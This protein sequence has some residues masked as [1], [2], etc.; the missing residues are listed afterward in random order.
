MGFG[1]KARQLLIVLLLLPS[2]A[3]GALTVTDRGTGG[4]GSVQAS[5]TV[6]PASN[7]AAG[8]MGVLCYSGDNANGGSGANVP[9]TIVDSVGNTWVRRQSGS[10]GT[11]N[12]LADSA[13]YT[14]Q[15][16]TAFTT[17]DNLVITFVS[18]VTAKNWTLSEIAPA[19]GKIALYSRGAA[20]SSS[21]TGTPTINAGVCINQAIIGMAAA[22]SA[23]TFTGDADTT[24]G[25]WSTKQSTGV[26]SGASGNSILSQ[27][28]VVT[29][30]ADQTFN[31]TLTS[32]DVRLAWIGVEE[33]DSR[34]RAANQDATAGA[35]VTITF[36]EPIAAGSTAVLCL[37]ADNAGSNGSAANIPTSLT[38]SKSN[39][40][41]LRSTVI[42]DPGAASAGVEIGVYTSLLGTAI[43]RDD[44]VTVTWQAVNVTAKAW[45]VWEFSGYLYS[46]AAS[47]NTG[48]GTGVSQNNGSVPNANAVIAAVGIEGPDTVTA[49]DTDTTNGSWS[50]ALEHSSGSS[51]TG[52]M[53]MVSQYKIVNAT[54]TQTM[55]LTMTSADWAGAGVILAPPSSNNTAYLHFLD[56]FP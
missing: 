52:D 6:T 18:N 41:T 1:S 11:A 45:G 25:N 39:S 56:F 42:N 29:A 12:S 55:N 32:A 37:A 9:T 14:A 44:T 17:S 7:L 8:S 47:T 43:A 33:T 19:A 50:S 31:P 51:A 49:Y 26:G 28:K 53:T 46:S 20:G 30:T 54:G 35:S 22:E 23:D 13:I 34:A 16:T 38:D 5:I 2:A 4:S 21:A 3:F 15:L 24:N 36:T 48:T 40:W 10:G 27:A